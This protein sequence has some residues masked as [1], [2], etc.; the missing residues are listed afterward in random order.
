M[1]WAIDENV[2][3]VANDVARVDRGDQPNCPQADDACRLACVTFLASARRD[4]KVIVDGADV[5]FSYY[6]RKASLSGQPGSGDA[7]LKAL[8]QVMY[9]PDHIVR[10]DLAPAPTFGLP[11]AFVQSGFDPDDFIYVALAAARPNSII[12]NAVDSDYQIHAAQ[13]AAVPADVRELCGHCLT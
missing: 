8:F 10:V 2:I 6:R 11:A 12:I 5:V 1:N 7:F 13:I 4:G 9:D 3:A